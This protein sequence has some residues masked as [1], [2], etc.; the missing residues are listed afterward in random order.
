MFTSWISISDGIFPKKRKTV[1]GEVLNKDGTFSYGFFQYVFEE[2][3]PVKNQRVNC[4][5]KDA[6]DGYGIKNVVRWLPL[7]QRNT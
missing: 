2:W 1:V 7:K 5:G 6:L 4:D 3:R